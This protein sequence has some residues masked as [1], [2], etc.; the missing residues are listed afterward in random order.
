MR[1]AIG[2]S[3]DVDRIFSDNAVNTVSADALDDFVSKTDALGGPNSV[4]VQNYWAKFRYQ[5]RTRVDESLDPFGEEYFAQQLN[6]YEEISGRTLD[7]AV[8]ERFEFDISPH[9]NAHNPYNHPDPTVF[10]RQLSTIATVCNVVAMPGGAKALDMGCGWGLSSETLAYCGFQVESVDINPNFVALVNGRAKRLGLP[11]RAVQSTFEK[12]APPDG[13]L[14]DFSLFY[15][16]FHHSPKPW[17]LMARVV[18]MLKFSGKFVLATEPV[19]ATHW[20][21]WGLRLDAL[22]VY[23]IRKYGWFE[24]GWSLPFLTK[25]FERNNLELAVFPAPSTTD[26]IYIG[27]QKGILSISDLKKASNH[28]DW[29]QE[30]EWIVSKGNSV[31]AIPVH[32]GTQRIDIALSNYRKS[33]INLELTL[34]NESRKFVLQPG[35][36]VVSIACRGNGKI[37]Q[38][39]FV[40]DAWCPSEELKVDDQRTIS[41]HVSAVRLGAWFDGTI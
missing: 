40:S 31:L 36:H 41:L 11:I 35:P 37:Q 2:A 15:E 30:E 19:Q 34:G 21:N 28:T 10:A 14:F 4:G 25:M 6:L 29:F 18:S 24:S 17:E 33:H 1:R 32:T 16:C 22:S 13:Q 7:Q 26:A 39:R 9:L 3:P 38:I 12:Y 8:N 5:L 23:C 20:R 27:C